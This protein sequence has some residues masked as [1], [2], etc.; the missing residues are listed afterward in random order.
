MSAACVCTTAEAELAPEGD[1]VRSPEG[2][3]A[4]AKVYVSP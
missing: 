3:R 2:E 1:H 4:L